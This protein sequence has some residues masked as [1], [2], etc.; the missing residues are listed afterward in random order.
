MKF[1][2]VARPLYIETDTFGIGLGANYYRQG[3]T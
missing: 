2:D 1:Y 3:M